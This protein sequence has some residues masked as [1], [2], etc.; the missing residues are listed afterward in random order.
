MNRNVAPVYKC[1]DAS[2]I[3]FFRNLDMAKI[4]ST[5]LSTAVTITPTNQSS[6]KAFQSLEEWGVPKMKSLAP[7]KIS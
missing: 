6:V 2:G 5:S 4:I 7:E 3:H 1:S